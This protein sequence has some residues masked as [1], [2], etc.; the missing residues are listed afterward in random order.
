MQ[1]SNNA[2]QNYGLEK[3]IETTP[4]KG[5]EF[6][7]LGPKREPAQAGRP[8]LSGDQTSDS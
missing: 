2:T 7:S 3:A 8:D 5:L 6:G 4:A 1:P